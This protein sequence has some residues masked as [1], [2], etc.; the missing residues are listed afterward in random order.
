M[1]RFLPKPFKQ[2]IKNVVYYFV[3][4]FDLLT[5][6]RDPLTPPKRIYFG[7]DGDF[8][9]IGEEFLN[10]FITLANLQPNH[11]VLDVGSGIGRMA[12]PLTK[13][14]NSNGVYYGFDIVPKGVAWC[15]KAISTRYS[16][17]HFQLVDVYNKEYNPKG[18]Y[19]ASE[20][21]F[22]FEA[23]YFDFVFAT[24]VFT[25][26]LPAD[27]DNYLNQIS[28]VL[29]QGGSFL[30]TFFLINDESQ[31]LLTQ[32][33]SSLDFKYNFGEYLSIHKDVPEYAI[34]Y[35][36]EYVRELYKK[37]GLII[38]EPI[39]YGSWCGRQQFLSY[40]D[41]VIATKDTAKHLK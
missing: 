27:V 14:L 12:V 35:Y 21:I 37:H 28:R 15:Q 24:S 39:Y 34:A 5:G 32:K 26:M 1:T 7:G 11:K 2:L 17:F 36:E 16:N 23:N 3:D 22:P 40:Q 6:R 38:K 10:Y 19:K 29:K 9:Q 4:C 8:K 31:V 13:Y 20:F 30:A 41:I 18:K 33:K 25:H